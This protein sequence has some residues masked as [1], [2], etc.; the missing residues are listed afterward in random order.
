MSKNL[1]VI[2]MTGERKFNNFDEFKIMI[3]DFLHEKTDKYFSCEL[4]SNVD[5]LCIYSAQVLQIDEFNCV[6]RYTFCYH[7]SKKVTYISELF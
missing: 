6:W 1:D 5:D 2:T 7:F 4:I 3:T